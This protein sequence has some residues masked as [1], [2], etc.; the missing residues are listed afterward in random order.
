MGLEHEMPEL[1]GA[2]RELRAVLTDGLDMEELRILCFDMG[3][4][5]DNL[6]GG[7]K[8]GKTASL[9]DYCTRRRMLDK[10]ATVLESSHPEIG[11]E[12]RPLVEEIVGRRAAIYE[13]RR[14][15]Q[16]QREKQ[17]ESVFREATRHYILGDLAHALQL[18]RYVKKFASNYPRIDA[19][20]DEISREMKSRYITRQ[21]TVDEEVLRSDSLPNASV[22]EY[23]HDKYAQI[24]ADMFARQNQA[25]KENAGRKFAEV[26][27]TLLSRPYVL[28]SLAIL[29]AFILIYVFGRLPKWSV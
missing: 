23:L 27:I 7:S 16:E 11:G 12:I 15:R 6:R 9:L 28:A 13:M 4:D 29:L 19:I 5:Y 25:N 3:V 10:L 17:P 2:L 20:I 21:G 26:V 22:T 8:R 18:Y 1:Q 24:L 14:K